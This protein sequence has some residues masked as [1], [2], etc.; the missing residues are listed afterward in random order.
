MEQ[1]STE[2]QDEPGND[3]ER[4]SQKEQR[5]VRVTLVASSP[6]KSCGMRRSVLSKIQIGLL[7]VGLMLVG[8]YGVARMESYY[9]SR[10]AI[11]QFESA[12]P[13][14]L[15]HQTEPQA[16]LAAGEPDFRDWGE[17]RI[18]AY[19]ASANQQKAVPM[20][21]LQIPSL[22]LKAPVFDGTD[23]LTLNHGVGRIEGTAMPGE[24]GNIG[25]AAHRDGFFR[26]LKDIKAGDT[27][28]LKRSGGTDMYTVDRIEIVDPSNVSVLQPQDQP[29][30]TLV[31]CYPF[32][33]VGSAPKRFVVT[34][35]LVQPTTTAGS[36][37]SEARLNSQQD[38]QSGSTTEEEQ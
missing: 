9:S 2:Q 23:D 6:G 36:T 8:V 29:A 32:Y 22:K 35:Y 17:G 3:E 1:Q 24:Q 11:E 34:A 38:S 4:M 27:I 26:G 19:Q 33:F 10:A 31:T 5:E 13:S 30:L 21:V 25:L 16:D 14:P 20:A 15:G 12:K 18:R 37:T 28:E 7:V